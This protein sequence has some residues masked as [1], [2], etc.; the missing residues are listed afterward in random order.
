MC[1]FNAVSFQ[2]SVNLHDRSALLSLCT[3]ARPEICL[4]P[5]NIRIPAQEGWRLASQLLEPRG[6]EQEESRGRGER[7]GRRRG[8]PLGLVGPSLGPVEHGPGRLPCNWDT[9]LS[10]RK[11]S[12]TPSNPSLCGNI[13]LFFFLLKTVSNFKMSNDMQRKNPLT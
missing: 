9:D 7:R 6:K 10:I 1:Y 2:R 4:S 5:E 13:S 3:G 12:R 8:L 11:K